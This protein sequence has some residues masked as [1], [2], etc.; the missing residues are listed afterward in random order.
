MP[1]IS[2][3]RR[4][5]YTP[6]SIRNFSEGVGVTKR[7]T[8]V[9]VAK[10][11]N[12]LREDLNKRSL[13]V[14]AVLDPLKVVITNYPDNELEYVNA[15]NNPEDES[16]GKR[17]LAFSKEIYI[18]RNDFMEEPPKKFF[19]LSLGKAVRLKFAYYITCNEVIKDEKGKIIELRCTY[20]PVTK[21]GRSDDGRKVRGTLHWV[22]AEENIKAKIR[23]YDRLFNSEHPEKNGDFIENINEKSLKII[24]NAVLENSFNSEVSD[25]PYQF[26]RIGY[27][28]IDSKNSTPDKLVFNRAVSL[29]DSWARFNKKVG[30]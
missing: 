30:H 16:A 23:L 7:D 19:R 28:K 4:R 8:V 15:I 6:E 21:G 12:S 13:R 2:G 25:F 18:E 24:D 17:K 10:L 22:S 5:G 26:E 27:F 11:E 29:R 9:D 14:M 1:T 20:D 3:L